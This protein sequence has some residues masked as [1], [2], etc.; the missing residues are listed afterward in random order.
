[1]SRLTNAEIIALEANKRGYNYNGSNIHTYKEWL[2]L[3]HQVKQGQTAFI[4]TYLW[5]SGTN[6]RK[7]LQGLFT[8]EQV[9]KVNAKDL[10]LA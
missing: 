5:N 4:K 2:D 6:R 10:I 3:G 8:I 7:I 9:V 1:M